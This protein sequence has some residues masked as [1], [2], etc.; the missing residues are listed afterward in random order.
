MA[1]VNYI[2]GIDDILKNM[3]KT[4][5]LV[6]K[7]FEI[8]LKRAGLFLQKMSQRVVPVDTS[9]L[10]NSAF[11]RSAFS[12]TATVVTVGY[13]AAYAIF[14]HERMELSHKPGKQAKFLEQP[15]LQYHEQILKL[16]AEE[17]AL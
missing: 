6:G 14:V 7:K 15:A 3:R 17:A 9:N 8:G 13:T 1:V 4:D 11:T 5:V 2:T 12:G 16:I 10:K